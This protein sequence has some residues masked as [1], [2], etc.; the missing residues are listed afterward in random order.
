MDETAEEGA[1]SGFKDGFAAMS[2]GRASVEPYDEAM[3][4]KSEPTCSDIDPSDHRTI[5]ALL[6]GVCH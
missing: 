3:S 1:A 4:N 5:R 6:V 2:S